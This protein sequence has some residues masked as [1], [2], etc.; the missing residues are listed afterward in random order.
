MSDP[1]TKR[2]LVALMKQARAFGVGVGVATQNPMDLDYRALSNGAGPRSTRRL[3]ISR[4][5]ARHMEN[6]E[7][8]CTV[9]GNLDMVVVLSSGSSIWKAIR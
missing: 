5:K 1:P 3:P 9:P 4:T 7:H 8:W 2:P 6:A